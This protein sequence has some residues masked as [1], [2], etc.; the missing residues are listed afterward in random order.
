VLKSLVSVP[1]TAAS[2]SRRFAAASLG[3]AGVPVHAVSVGPS[4]REEESK[5]SRRSMM[6]PVCS[7]TAFFDNSGAHPHGGVDDIG[8]ALPLNGDQAYLRLFSIVLM[9]V[10]Y[11]LGRPFNHCNLYFF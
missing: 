8:T 2:I 6:P 5:N 10:T 9:F 7:D 4:A 3:V 11:K 1:S